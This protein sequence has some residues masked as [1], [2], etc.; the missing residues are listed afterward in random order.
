MLEK[1]DMMKVAVRNGITDLKT[2]RDKYN[3]F[4]EGGR[5]DEEDN[6]GNTYTDTW[7]GNQFKKGGRKKSPQSTDNPATQQAMQYFINKGLA[8][9][10]AAGLV[11][12]LFR[13]SRLNPT[14][15]NASSGAY[16]IA[17]WLG[18]RKK[19][20]FAKYGKNPTLNQQLDYVW[21]ELGNT[22]RTGL[23]AI[24]S[25]KNAEEAARNAMGY[26]E[27]SAGPE[28]AIREMRRWGQDGEGAMQKGI[29]FA[30][31]LIGGPVVPFRAETPQWNNIPFTPANPEVFFS[32]PVTTSQP[33]VDMEPT[34]T[35]ML[36]YDPK[37]A[38]R[39]EKRDNL[40]RF[41]MFLSM[42]NG[43]NENTFPF[44]MFAEGGKIH[45]SPSKKGTF[46]A[47]ASRHNMG[48][49]E[50]ASKVL[51]NKDDYSSAMVRK[52]NFARNASRWK[53]GL[54]GIFKAVED[55]VEKASLIYPT[56]SGSSRRLRCCNILR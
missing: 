21:H 44:S 45:I 30:S 40:S 28:A 53:H 37:E 51:A 18:D 4:A 34:K 13:E 26:Y 15:T 1:S 56:P 27:F 14:A 6:K 35:P 23:K 48:V 5:K 11:G 41:N 49:Q 7:T 20:L 3:E 16:G 24:K 47:A 43:S 31:Q 50:F 10:Q 22:H 8:Q 55:L 2:I 39:Q 17:Q 19:N 42:L 9:H 36:E 25:S 33:V 29:N 52:A 46:T 12:N 54:G 38:E 32:N